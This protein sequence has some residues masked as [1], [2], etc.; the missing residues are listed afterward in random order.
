MFN[1]NEKKEREQIK[2]N[3]NENS[4]KHAVVPFFIEEHCTMYIVL[5]IRALTKL[6]ILSDLLF[7]TFESD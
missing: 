6:N 7:N 1:E 5:T 4:T 3:P 2:Q